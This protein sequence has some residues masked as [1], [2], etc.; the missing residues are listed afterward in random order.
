MPIGTL[1][2]NSFVTFQLPLE[3]R[4]DDEK[5]SGAIF[6]GI[7]YDLV[8][9]ADEEA[10]RNYFNSLQYLPPGKRRRSSTFAAT[11]TARPRQATPR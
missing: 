9:G 11:S 8:A 5:V 4:T 7:A 1:K 3:A 10:Y 2:L 6:I